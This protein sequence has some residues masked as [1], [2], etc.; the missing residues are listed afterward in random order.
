MHCISSLPF[1]N[2]SLCIILFFVHQL[3]F[4]GGRDRRRMLTRRHIGMRSD[5]S[6]GYCNHLICTGAQ[7]DAIQ[8][9]M[10]SS[11][12]FFYFFSKAHKKISQMDTVTI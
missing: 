11:G 2:T 5:I 4:F 10:L 9:A 8:V 1:G 12:P 7:S 3:F 6:N